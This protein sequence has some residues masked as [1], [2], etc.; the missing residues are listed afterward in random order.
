LNPEPAYSKTELLVVIAATAFMAYSYY[1]F[2]EWSK[3]EQERYHEEMLQD[4]RAK[5]E[6]VAESN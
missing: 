5:V 2:L 1:Q 6:E 4:Y 3:R